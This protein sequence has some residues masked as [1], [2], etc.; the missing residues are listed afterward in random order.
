M[1]GSDAR[2][3]S[4]LLAFYQLCFELIAI[5][6]FCLPCLYLR[7]PVEYDFDDKCNEVHVWNNTFTPWKRYQNMTALPVLVFLCW[8]EEDWCDWGLWEACKSRELIFVAF[9]FFPF[10][11]SVGPVQVTSP[12]AESMHKLKLTTTP[13]KQASKPPN[14]PAVTERHVALFSHLLNISPTVFLSCQVKLSP[15]GSLGSFCL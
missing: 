15:L 12:K 14:S 6:D 5:R 3:G 11:R 8:P 9:F 1:S 2:F 7:L 10:T 4:S 13:P